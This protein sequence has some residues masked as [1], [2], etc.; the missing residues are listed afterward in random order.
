MGCGS[1]A[2][3][4][5][6]FTILYTNKKYSWTGFFLLCFLQNWFY[7]LFENTYVLRIFILKIFFLATHCTDIIL[8]LLYYHT[9]IP[10]YMEHNSAIYSNI[11]QNKSVHMTY[12][13]VR[14]KCVH[15]WP[16]HRCTV[17]ISVTQSTALWQNGQ[18]KWTCT[19]WNS[20]GEFGIWCTGEFWHI[21][22]KSRIT[23]KLTG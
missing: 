4:W 14:W 21:H 23:N 6:C 3:M 17:Y 15:I 5:S 11:F 12:C 2:V 10:S 19:V 1:F 16:H 20:P 7:S 18:Q 8:S 13:T 9:Y 22:L